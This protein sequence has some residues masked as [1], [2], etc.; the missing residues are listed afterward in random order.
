[1]IDRNTPLDELPELLRVD[2]AARWLD[3]S[4][5][6]IYE[7]ARRRPDFGVRLGRLLRLRRAV[8][9][10]MAGS[11]RDGHHDGVSRADGRRDA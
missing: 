8:L 7:Q 10:E 1:M 3:C 6:T 9:A 2:E 4:R 5:G 11:D